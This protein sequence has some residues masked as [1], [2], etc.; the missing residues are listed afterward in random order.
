MKR[1]T[2]IVNAIAAASL[3]GIGTNALAQQSTI[4]G[5]YT[6]DAKRSDDINATIESGV[7]NMNFIVRPIARSRLKKTNPAYQRIVISHDASEIVV[8][9]DAR[10]PIRMPASGTSIKWTRED[11]EKFDLKGE[12]QES[13]LKQTYVAEDGT[14]INEFQASKDGLTMTLHVTLISE[15][16]DKPL[17]YKLSYQRVTAQ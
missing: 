10:K 2:F 8:T 13:M 17:Q 14:R 9:L 7:A 16:L 1:S 4:D 5:T 6:F 15:R 3:I 12:L 11:G